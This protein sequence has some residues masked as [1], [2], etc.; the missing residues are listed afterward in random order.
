MAT[1]KRSP[2]WQFFVECEDTRFARCKDCSEN[3]SRG[4]KTTKTY[5]TSNLVIHLKK[6]SLLYSDYLEKKKRFDEECEMTA[7]GPSGAGTSK[8]VTLQESYNR[9]RPWD[10]NDKRSV[11]VHQKIGEMIALDFQPFPVVSDEGFKSLLHTL[12]PRYTLPSRRYF[13][14]TVLTRIHQ[15]IVSKLKQEI[16]SAPSF[17]FTT[18]IWSTEVSDDSM[19]SLTAHWINDCFV[20]KEAVLHVQS[21]PESHTGENICNTFNTML[22]NWNIEKTSVH[23][24]V[25]DNA[26]NMVKA[27]RDGGYSDLGCFAHTLQLVIHDAVFSQ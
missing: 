24:V 19:I 25:R 6:H 21:F 8:Q 14:D 20:K 12:E 7:A 13:T 18:D 23:L 17:S 16:A 1:R 4:G 15:G 3:V 2:I 11:R 5:N 26:S 10:I 27:F 22:E 9:A